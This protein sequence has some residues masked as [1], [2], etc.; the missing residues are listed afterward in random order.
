MK[1]KKYING[2]VSVI[3]PCYN[4]QAYLE[5]AIQ[6]VLSQSYSSL[7]LLIIDD[8]STKPIKN[9]ISK[10]I[11]DKRVR[12]IQHQENQGVAIA[13][14]TGLKN[15]KGRYVAFLDSDDLWHKNKLEKQ[16]NFLWNHQVAFV[17]SEYEVIRKTSDDIINKISVPYTIDYLNL[18]KNT[19]I[20]CSTVLIDRKATD[21]FEMPII[22]VG[23]DTATWLNILK[24]GHIAY[25][26]QEPLVKY[27]VSDYSLSKNKWK[28]VRGTWKMYRITQSLSFLSTCFYFSHYACNATLKRI[29]K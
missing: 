9:I 28:M 24:K 20:G 11:Y 3:M 29:R 16:L 8:A 23:E 27:R 1:Q 13:R 4:G 5:E 6:S 12:L 7:E 14:N 21:S 22:S 25:G 26:I 10:F 18:L 17:F 15:S 19:I 2:L